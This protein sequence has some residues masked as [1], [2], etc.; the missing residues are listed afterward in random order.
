M[1]GSAAVTS[2]EWHL[3]GCYYLGRLR[4][5]WVIRAKSGN[6]GE[7]DYASMHQLSITK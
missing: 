5:F 2:P 7:C 4:F 1:I 6:D 3:D